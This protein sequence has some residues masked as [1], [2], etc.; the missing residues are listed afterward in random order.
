LAS[1]VI[2]VEVFVHFKFADITVITLCL[3]LL[4]FGFLDQVVYFDLFEFLR[5]LCELLLD[6]ALLT[7]SLSLHLHFFWL[8]LL[9]CL[10]FLLMLSLVFLFVVLGIRE[11]RHEVSENSTHFFLSLAVVEAAGLIEFHL[12]IE[13]RGEER[14]CQE[15]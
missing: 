1:D 8:F 4:V 15:A 14:I 12:L 11:P 7:R 6:H 13:P 10:L 3:L 9:L 2:D 5:L